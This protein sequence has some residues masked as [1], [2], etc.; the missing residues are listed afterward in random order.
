MCTRITCP[1]CHKPSYAG[2]GA[3]VEHVLRDVPEA[4]RCKCREE[5]PSGRAEPR[6]GE[7]ELPRLWKRLF[8]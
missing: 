3:H 7:R 4:E 1:R 6:Q 2:C 8:G 5:A